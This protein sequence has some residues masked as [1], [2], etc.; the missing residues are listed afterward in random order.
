MSVS[1]VLGP[2]AVS[3]GERDHNVAAGLWLPVRTMN[4]TNLCLE[5]TNCLRFTSIR[6]CHSCNSTVSK[7]TD[8]AGT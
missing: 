8:E 5:Q 2:T 7:S 6:I 4:T 1:D 3:A